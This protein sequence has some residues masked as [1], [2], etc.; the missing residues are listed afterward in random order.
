MVCLL[1]LL[2]SRREK[3]SSR[4]VKIIVAVYKYTPKLTGNK[5]HHPE[6]ADQKS[7]NRKE[8]NFNGLT[9]HQLS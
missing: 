2:S 7:I 8:L 6:T 5:K 9:L 4:I 3:M 1:Y